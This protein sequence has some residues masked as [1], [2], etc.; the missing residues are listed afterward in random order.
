MYRPDISHRLPVCDVR[1]RSEFLRQKEEERKKEFTPDTLNSVKSRIQCYLEKRRT[2]HARNL[3]QSAQNSYQ[4]VC[5]PSSNRAWLKMTYNEPSWPSS[6]VRGVGK[7]R[8][9]GIYLSI[10]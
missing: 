4:R 10:L 8:Q 6:L 9:E 2:V 5:V 3:M 1:G 7:T